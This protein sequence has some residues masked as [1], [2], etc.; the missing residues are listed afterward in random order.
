MD[1]A[2][3]LYKNATPNI[4][5]NARLLRNNMTLAERVLWERIRRKQIKSARFR[6][7]HAIDVFI[8][9]FY[10]HELLLGIE[11]DGSIHNSIEAKER[12]EGRSAELLKYGIKVIR[13]TNEEVLYD[14]DS[15]IKEVEK[16]I[17][18][19]KV[20]PLQGGRI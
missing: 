17:D 14:I 1:Y 12:D 11:V 15:V 13:F 20:L 18:E 3:N 19:L 7:Q 4:L 10:C 6:N 9:D 16:I 8:I 5:E 2:N